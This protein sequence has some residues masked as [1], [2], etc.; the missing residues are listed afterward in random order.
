MKPHIRRYL[1]HFGYSTA[2]FVPCEI[3]ECGKKAQ[4]IHHISCRGMGGDPKNKR[5]GIENLMALCRPH[6]LEFGDIKDKKEWLNEVH[7]AFLQKHK[8]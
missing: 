7:L 3:P 2:D 5:G 4:D 8:K 1:S 6:H